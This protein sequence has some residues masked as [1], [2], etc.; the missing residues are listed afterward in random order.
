M[1]KF[2]LVLILPIIYS[3]P[4][5]FLK[6]AENCCKMVKRLKGKIWIDLYY[7]NSAD[8]NLGLTL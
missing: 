8:G 2:E 6:K 1:Y 3:E 7:W 4:K 5:D